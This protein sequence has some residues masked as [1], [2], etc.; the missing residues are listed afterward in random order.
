MGGQGCAKRQST[1]ASSQ[2]FQCLCNVA[3]PGS[4]ANNMRWIKGATRVLRQST[5]IT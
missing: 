5:N 4:S 2:S 3:L 1:S